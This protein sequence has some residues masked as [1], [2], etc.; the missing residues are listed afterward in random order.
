MTALSSPQTFD[1]HVTMRSNLIADPRLRPQ[2]SFFLRVGVDR[3]PAPDM[4]YI[5]HLL[6]IYL[7]IHFFFF[8]QRLQS[9][10]P[11]VWVLSKGA[12]WYEISNR[13]C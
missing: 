7:Y 2:A 8:L 5:F 10:D 6:F 11:S 4:F 1:F 13:E 12:R 3:R 9:D